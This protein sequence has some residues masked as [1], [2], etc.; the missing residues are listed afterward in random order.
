[1]FSVTSPALNRAYNHYAPELLMVSYRRHDFLK[2][3]P[4]KKQALTDV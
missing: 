3:I 1:M 2:K 4:A